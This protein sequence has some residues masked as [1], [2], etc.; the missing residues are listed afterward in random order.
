MSAHRPIIR[1]FDKLEDKVREFLSHYPI[2]YGIIGGIGTVLVWRGIWHTADFLSAHYFGGSSGA[3]G[4]TDYPIFLDGF[5]S[6]VL[7]IIILLMTGLFVA[8]FIG[9]HII[10]SGL[11][12]EKKVAE[13]T[14]EEVKSEESALSAIHRQ[15]HDISERL[16][17]IEKKIPGKNQ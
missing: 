3:M 5:V 4:T 12:H 15:L 17:K 6:L 9:D 10:I 2:L 8:S 13:K 16:D 14:E 1:F 7:G 11:K